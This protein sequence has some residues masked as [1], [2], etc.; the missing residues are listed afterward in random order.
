VFF[1]SQKPKKAA[2]IM[3]ANRV[4]GV[5]ER[6][7]IPEFE[8]QRKIL[9]SPTISKDCTKIAF[10]VSENGST[11]IYIFNRNTEKLT[12]LTNTKNTINT[13]PFFFNND[14]KIIFVSDRQGKANIW[15]MKIDG[16]EQKRISQGDGAYY[17]PSVS[18]D[19]K[20]IA[21]VKVKSGVFSLGI[22]N[23][24]GSK[25]DLIH[26]AF[27]IENPI[28]APIGKTIIFSMKPSSKEKSR[29]YAISFNGRKPEELPALKGSLNEPKWVDEF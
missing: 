20:K 2:E 23:T 16:S 15:E 14:K 17:S 22:A 18:S 7:I 10:S 11:N 25:E 26:S 24:D 8:N 27:L 9:F 5:V 29:V 19:G 3:I 6:L 12:M 28:W 4:S 1:T 13:A 21:F